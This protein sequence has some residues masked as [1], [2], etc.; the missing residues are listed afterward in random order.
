MGLTMYRSGRATPPDLVKRLF[1]PNR[2]NGAPMGWREVDLQRFASI[3]SC[4]GTGI[5]EAYLGAVLFDS[6]GKQLEEP[7]NGVTAWFYA[8][9]T[10]L[11]QCFV[12]DYPPGRRGP[13]V[14]TPRYFAFGCCHDA[15]TYTADEAAKNGWPFT[16]GRCYRNARCRKCGTDLSVDSSD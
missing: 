5:G 4:Y 1:N 15:Q 7:L 11:A 8:D 9:N 10:G 3:F 2:P 14:Y 12:Y 6:D 13:C 16:Y